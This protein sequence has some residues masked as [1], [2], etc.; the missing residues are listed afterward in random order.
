MSRQHAQ[1][2]TVGNDGYVT[3]LPRLALSGTGT[4][5]DEGFL[6][7]LIEQCPEILPISEIDSS[8]DSV[9]HLC[10][11]MSTNAGPIDNMLVTRTGQPVVVECKLWRNPE[12]RREVIGQILDY[13]KELSRFSSADLQR[14]VN[15][16]LG[17]SGDVVFDRVNAIYPELDQIAFNDSLTRNLRTGRIML[18]IVGDGIRE[19][20]ESITE[21][22]ALHSGL[23]F[24]LGLVELPVFE[25][26]DGQK[27]VTPRVVAHTVLVRRT[28]YERIAEGGNAVDEQVEEDAKHTEPSAPTDR[29][30]MRQFWTEFLQELRLDDPQQPMAKPARQ[31]YISFSLPVPGS[32]GWLTVYRNFRESRV[33]LFF[34]Y[35]TGTIGEEVARKLVAEWDEGLSERFQGGSAGDSNGRLFV[36]DRLSVRSLADESERQG[37]F[38]WLRKRTNDFINALR[39][40][41]PRVLSELDSNFE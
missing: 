35:T 18:L 2:V 36:E 5:V 17:T 3:R 19:G 6:Q 10:R 39:S 9:V 26:P 23:H 25:M 11:E 32:N 30:E 4:R 14:E 13:A 20:V 27:L 22:V 15:K 21:Y 37:A 34:G 7:K 40:E 24:T 31:G 1:P 41:I 16:R 12:A 8:F 38:E 28:V 29:E 33:G